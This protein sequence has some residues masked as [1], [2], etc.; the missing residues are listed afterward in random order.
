MVGT[1]P[2]FA[3]F[4]SR[5]AGFKNHHRSQIRALITRLASAL[6]FGACGALDWSRESSE[7]QV[8][9][10]RS[11]SSTDSPGKRKGWSLSNCPDDIY[12]QLWSWAKAG[13]TITS[14]RQP[15]PSEDTQSRAPQRSFDK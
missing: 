13:S 10:K 15:S 9:R 2:S 7:S 14:T 8:R 4:F 3:H 11:T 5:G 12:D 1:H 6:G